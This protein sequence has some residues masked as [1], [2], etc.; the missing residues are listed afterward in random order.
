MLL[1][2]NESFW[3]DKLD[4]GHKIRPPANLI[5]RQRLLDMA[6]N[7]LLPFLAGVAETEN[8]P[9]LARLAKETFLILPLPQDNR[10]V[11]EAVQRFLNPPSRIVDIVKSACH[12]Q[13]ILDIYNNFCLALDNNCQFCPFAKG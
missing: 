10:M 1:A 5:G 4:F 8:A 11:K 12:Q 9:E 7:V 6:A 3:R 13:G 2:D